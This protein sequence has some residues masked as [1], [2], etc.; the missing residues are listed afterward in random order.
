MEESVNGVEGV[1]EILVDPTA[2]A[3][4]RDR[5]GSGEVIAERAGE[6]LSE[7]FRGINGASGQARDARSVACGP[8]RSGHVQVEHAAVLQVHL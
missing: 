4:H 5:V 1:V 6:P 2:G 7:G 3:G 8:A